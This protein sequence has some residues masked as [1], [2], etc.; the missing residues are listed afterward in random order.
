MNATRAFHFTSSLDKIRPIN[1]KAW[2]F[3][4]S[5]DENLSLLF[6]RKIFWMFIREVVIVEEIWCITRG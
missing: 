1:K 6:H 5:L 3:E 4:I 2:W